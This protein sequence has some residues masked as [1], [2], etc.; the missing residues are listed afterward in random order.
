[1]KL[2]KYILIFLVL[3]FGALY[4]GKLLMGNGPQTEWY[5]SLTQA[6]WTPPG[7]IFGLAWTIIMVCF[8]IYMSYLYKLLLKT[9]VIILFAIQ[10]VLNIIWNF[11]FFNLHHVNAAFIIILLLTLIVSIF[12]FFYIKEMK[13]KTVLILPYLIWL[14]I[15]TS[16]NGY[17]L[18]YN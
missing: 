11:V 9:Q 17:I 3:N 16:L 4:I 1:M 8:S 5:S 15:A 18:L 6:P 12:T 14:C 13:S 2:F 7:W 10:F